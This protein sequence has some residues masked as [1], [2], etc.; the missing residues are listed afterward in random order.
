MLPEC[1]KTY[2]GQSD[3]AP[4][5]CVIGHWVALIFSMFVTHTTGVC[6]S[7]SENVNN[8]VSVVNLF[9]LAAQFTTF[10]YWF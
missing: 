6:V 8:S 10:F 9:P 1:V 5:V 4:T 2:A 7:T 3:H